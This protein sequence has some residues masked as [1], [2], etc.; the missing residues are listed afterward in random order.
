M[1]RDGSL[2]IMMLLGLSVLVVGC[3][4]RHDTDTKPDKTTSDYKATQSKEIV[5]QNVLAAQLA[6]H[7]EIESRTVF[8]PT[9]QICASVYLTNPQHVEPRR[10]SAF[11]LHDESIIEEQSIDINAGEARQAFDF[12]FTETPRPSG[13]YQIKFVEIKRSNGKPVLLARLF[14]SV[15]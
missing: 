6:R 1:K 7:N 8:A 13:A 14:L 2:V 9:E 4:N 15:E 10:I 5:A 3:D 12:S 11:L